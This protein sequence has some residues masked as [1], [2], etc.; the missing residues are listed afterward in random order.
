MT[1]DNYGEYWTIDHVYPCCEY[2]LTIEDNIYQC[3]NWRN[4]RPLIKIKNYEK[5]NKIDPIELDNHI[6]FIKDFVKYLPDDEKN[7]YI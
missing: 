2:D 1:F 7:N 6:G 4:L 3:F 5:T